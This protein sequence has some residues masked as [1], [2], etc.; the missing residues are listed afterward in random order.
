M[1]LT[2]GYARVSTDQQAHDKALRDQM[3]RLKLSGADKVIVDIASRTNDSRVGLQEVIRLVE[4]GEI[5]KVLVTRLDRLTASPALFER[6]SETLQRQEVKLI[7]L[8]ENVDIHSVDGEFA[9]GLQV[10]FGRREVKTI[11]L[12][13][14]KAKET[15]RKHNRASS[16]VPWG[17][18]NVDGKYKL[19][20]TP[21][22]CLL[23]DRPP[24]GREIVGRTKAQLGRDIVET[25]FTA[26]SLSKTVR[27]IH[28]K[29]GIWK[30]EHKEDEPKG[31]VLIFEEDFDYKPPKN[32]RAGL[33]RWSRDG[34]RNFLINPV[35]A[36]HTP[37]GLMEVKDGK[38]KEKPPSDWDIR[39]D[40]HPDERMMTDTEGQRIKEMIAANQQLGGWGTRND[41]HPLTGLLFCLECGRAMR[42]GG[43]KKG[44]GNRRIVYYQCRGW[45]ERACTARTMIKESD[46]EEPIISALTQKAVEL[47]ELTD[48]PQPPDQVEPPELQQLKAQLVGLEQLGTNPAFEA[49]KCDLKRQI[50]NFHHSMSQQAEVENQNR[51]LLLNVFR[52][53]LYWETL[54]DFEKRTLYHSLV[55]R[56]VIRNGKVA[57]VRLKV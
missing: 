53:R 13:I 17:Y 11:R 49:A 54:L 43:T 16:S 32:T 42:V 7:A 37:Y 51:E 39:Y 23:S 19:D 3:L 35:L 8:D 33:F 46:V 55:E 45:V 14:L 25:F 57:E 15:G 29:Y 31:K 30:S 5:S 21:F 9:A 20:Y 44:K 4:V 36:G 48:C 1:K 26:G 10:Y 6:L 40:T 56:V 22:L 18:R 28:E 41:P 52:N 38:R 50:A 12:R 2:I 34:I 24:D 27:D 47:A